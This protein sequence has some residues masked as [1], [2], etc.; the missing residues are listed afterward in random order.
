[1]VTVGIGDVGVVGATD[2][3]EGGSSVNC[4][5]GRLGMLIVLVRYGDIGRFVNEGML[6][7][8]DMF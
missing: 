5:F 6:S 8:L 4:P 1:M 2:A 7:T 3:D